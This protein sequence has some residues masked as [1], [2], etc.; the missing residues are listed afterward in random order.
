MKY[1]L[2]G[3]GGSYN[4]GGEAIIQTTCEMIRRN[5]SDALIVLSTHFKEQD[6][7]FGVP[8][9]RYCVR[10]MEALQRENNDR[11]INH[12]T[13]EVYRE[14]I[15]EIEKNSVVFSVGGDNY[16]YD[17]WE[18]W[19]VIHNYAKQVG[20]KTVLWSCSIEPSMISEAMVAHLKTFDVIT[21]RENKTYEA[22][23]RAGLNNIK[24]CSDIA[25][26]LKPEKVELPKGFDCGNMVAINVSPLVLRREKF[27]GIIIENI[28]RCIDYILHNTAYKILL[29]PH[30][31]MSVDNDVEA[32]SEIK[33]YYVN[34]DR[35][36]LFDK[37]CS[38]G[39]YKYLISKCRFG[40]FSRTHASI[41]A[42]SSNIPSIVLGYSVKS[43]GIASDLGVEKY[44]LAIERLKK[45]S[46]LS[47]FQE[48]IKEEEKIKDMLC[49]NYNET[50]QGALKGREV[51]EDMKNG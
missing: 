11:N 10:D 46:L 9:D 49:E 16:C 14:V 7:E 25:F 24:K 30:V 31:L 33:K 22:L 29:I 23:L 18:K 20:A 48:L 15:S 51:L 43:F 36:I 19:T 39:Q 26:L 32:L 40:I 28:T 2:Y 4:H 38:A 12:F 35:V 47:S 13:A 50:I 45:E 8:V 5:D 17:N 41:S 34:D 27:S 37:N 6:E 42:Y 1:V 3:F 21:P 44:V